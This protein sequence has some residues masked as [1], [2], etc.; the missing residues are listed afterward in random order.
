MKRIA[1]I[2]MLILVSATVATGAPD[3]GT[4]GLGGLTEKQ[5]ATLAVGNIVF[6]TAD[7]KG[8]NKSSLIQAAIVFD[9]TPEQ[10]W[11]LLFRTQ[12]Q[13][14]YLK[15]IE[16]I[17][18]ISK[19]QAKDNLEFHLSVAWLDYVYRVIH[20]FDPINRYFHWGLDPTFKND[21][22]DLR[23]YW[24]LYPYGNGKTLARYGSNVSIKKVPSFVENMFKKNGVKKSLQ[25]VKKYINSNGTWRVKR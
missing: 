19:A 1:L 6:Y 11:S 18:I 9:K 20:R 22:K 4:D 2:M 7:V 5:K 8:K 15:E 12:D 17:N 10:V 25:A 3:F 13:I 24:K 14:K 21:L 23:G 16:K